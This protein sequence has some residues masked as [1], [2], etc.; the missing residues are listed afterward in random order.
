MSLWKRTD[1]VIKPA[2]KCSG[3]V[4]MSRDDYIVVM[5]HL[6]NVQ[7]YE[8]LQENLTEQFLEE[9]TTSLTEWLKDKHLTGRLSI[10]SDQIMSGHPSFIYCQKYTNQTYEEDPL[11]HP[12]GLPQKVYCGTWATIWVDK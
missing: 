2:D 9:I 8:E 3:M 10:S 12:E 5:D 6:N 4:V 7:V 1:I 11:L